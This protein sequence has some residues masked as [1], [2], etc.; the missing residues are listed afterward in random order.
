MKA[1]VFDCEANGLIANS[2]ITIDKQPRLLE[3]YGCIVESNGTVIQELEFLCNPEMKILK[4]VT[5]ITGITDEMVANEPI[6]K[7]RLEEL[8]EF[9]FSCDAVVGHNLQYDKSIIDFELKRAGVNSELFWPDLKI[10]TVE[11]TEHLKGYRLSLTDLHQH[12]FGYGFAGAHR[13]RVDVQATVKC[14]VELI[15]RGEI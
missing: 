2:G 13:A 10:C 4:E 7:K 3:F 8:Q 12:L 14:F 15:K 6:F 11:Q 1:A 5:N 9:F